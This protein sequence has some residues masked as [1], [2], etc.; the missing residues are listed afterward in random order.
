[1]KS[2]PCFTTAGP[3]GCFNSSNQEAGKKNVLTCPP[4]DFEDGGM[5]GLNEKVWPVCEKKSCADKCALH[6]MDWGKKCTWGICADCQM[7]CVGPLVT[8][9]LRLGA[10]SAN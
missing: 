10:Q 9:I 7:A 2:D 1:M 8:V 3:L 6:T 4:C 5:P